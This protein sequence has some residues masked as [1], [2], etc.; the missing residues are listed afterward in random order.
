MRLTQAEIAHAIAQKQAIA[1]TVAQ[2]AAENALNAA[3]SRGAMLLGLVGGPIG[4]I[5]IGVAALAA[6][7]MYLKGKTAEATAK[8]EEQGKVAEKTNEELTK[9][10]GNDKKNAVSDLTAAFNAQN[11][12]LSKSKEAVD[13]VLFAIRASSVE[14]EK[15]RKVT[16]DAKNGVISYNQAIELLNKM[17]ISPELYEMLKKQ[18]GQYDENSLKAGNSQR[19]LKILGVEFK[20]SGNAAQ[21]A[22]NQVK[23]NSAE[24][25]NNETAAQKA[26]RA[27]KQYTESLSGR[28]FDAVFTKNLLAK[29]F[30][31]G[32]TNALLEAANYARKQGVEFTKAMAQEALRLYNL[33]KAN[34]DTLEAKNEAEKKITKEKEKQQRVLEASTKVQANA[35]KYNF[36]GLESKYQLPKGTLSAIH[37]IETGNTGKTNQVNK[38]SGATGGFQF[39]KGTADQYGVKDR[40]DMAQSAEGAAKYMAY[41][42][43]LFKGDLEKAVRAYHAGEGNVQKG[44]NIGKYNNDYWSKFKGY[45][46]S[47]N[48]FTGG[49]VGA[50]EWEKQLEEATRLL[51]EQAELRKNLEFNI[52]SE[53][54]QIRSRLADDLLEIDK[55]GYSPEK[56]KELKAEYQARADNDIA[57]AQQALK[58]KLDD[59]GAFKK[60]ESELLKDSF[61]EKK[62]YAARDLE[63]TKDQ[64]DK[65]IALLD[66]QLKQEQGLLMLARETRIFQFEQAMY[67]EMEL[68]KKR[69]DFELQEAARLQDPEERARRVN[70]ASSTK[71]QDESDL[72][73]NSTINYSNAVGIDTSAEQALKARQDAIDKMRENDFIKQKEHEMRSIESMRQYERDKQDL[74]LNSMNMLLSTTSSTWSSMT[75]LIK[76]S[77]GEQSAVYKGMFLVQQAFAMTS[78]TINALQAYNQVLANPWTFDPITKQ[79]AASITLG[80]G[81]AGVGM[82]AAQTIAGFETGGYTGSGGRKD[83]AGVVHGQ[84]YVLNA[85]ATKR[86]GVGTLDAINAGK[87]LGGGGGDLIAPITVNVSVQSNGESSVDTQGQSKQ[88]GQMIGSAVRTVIRQEQRQGGL[89]AR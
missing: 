27:Q 34:K 4:A 61:D 77:V 71:K 79:T 28:T 29:N 54:K 36:G 8:L 47:E 22:A 38:Q 75:S 76:D 24:L 9:L 84:E 42:L 44:K 70:A 82:I 18:A 46:A 14:N 66:E 39:L 62:F 41:L 73:W 80:M 13:A 25:N 21:N 55:A 40:T 87:G 45:T 26:A 12:E 89:L 88:L 43:K 48:G 10:S 68:I 32:Q 67:T 31:E 57:I 20:L 50:K 2:T 53:V 59:Y 72:L 69:Y 86:V 30:T 49:D 5:T 52:A 6:G 60:T 58:T 11:A 17:D 33:E 81:M 19:V 83:V 65:A 7:Y 23:E 51:E 37:A 78:A 63:L 85:A 56:A 35:A 64:R 16:E 3:R 15:A 1:S 74:A